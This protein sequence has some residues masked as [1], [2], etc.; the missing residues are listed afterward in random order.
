MRKEPDI[1]MITEK[2]CPKCNAIKDV[3]EFYLDKSRIGGFARYCKDCNRTVVKDWKQSNSDRNHEQGR[4]YM[5]NY[6]INHPMKAKEYD[7]IRRSKTKLSRNISRS[8]RAALKGNKGGLHWENLVGYTLKQLK[9]HIEK[10]FDL[11]MTWDNYGKWHIDHKI[12][13]TAF[14]FIEPGDIDFKK[15]WSLQN[16]QPLEAKKN[17]IKNDKIDKPFQPSLA[18]SIS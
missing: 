15:C 12:P 5:K 11:W 14:N 16:L 6:R 8:M 9:S 10:Q 13:L 17:I 3:C 2:R 4:R 1:N 18:V 7:A